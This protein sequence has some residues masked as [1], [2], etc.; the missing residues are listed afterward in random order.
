MSSNYE[1]FY[2]GDMNFLDSI[3]REKYSFCQPLD[4]LFSFDNIFL[5]SNPCQQYYLNHFESEEEKIKL[6][7]T[8]EQSFHF[9][10]TSESLKEKKKEEE[11]IKQIQ[12]NKE[13]LISNNS[14][15]IE[16]KIKILPTYKKNKNIARYIIKT[17][18][19]FI[20]NEN[21]KIKIKCFD[22]MTDERY[23]K[24]LNY[25]ISKYNC[26]GC[27][28][29]IREHW[30]QNSINEEENIRNKHFLQFCNFFLKFKYPIYVLSEGRMNDENK[31]LYL[32]Y[33]K[34]LLKKLKKP[35]SYYKNS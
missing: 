26:F 23:E 21:F 2:L 29:I 22:L 13:N 17:I 10:Q 3:Q 5:N 31:K 27:I 24:F 28:K 35:E 34:F 9:F 4:S 20:K 19:N 11:K 8:E 32:K 14:K 25:F 33:A 30:L 15:K 16:K 18:L 1:D 12:K 7:T 6:N